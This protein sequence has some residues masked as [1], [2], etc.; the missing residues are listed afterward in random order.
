MNASHQLRLSGVLLIIAGILF[1]GFMFFHPPN[2]PQGAFELRWIPVHIAWFFSYILIILGFVPVFHSISTS[3][4][5]LEITAFW[6]SF[7]GTILSLPIA[8]W[9]A[10]LVPY[11]ARHTP[12]FITQIEELSMEAPAVSFRIIAYLAVLLFSIGYILMGISMVRAGQSIKRVCG[13]CLAVGASVFWIGA[14]FVSNGPLGNTVTIFGALL[15]GIGLIIWGY[16]I[17]SRLQT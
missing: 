3:G 16:L 13:I 7:L 11:L 2:N 5:K 4:R 8:A 1:G 6:I 14:L 12:D 9:D 10:F 15:F 17:S